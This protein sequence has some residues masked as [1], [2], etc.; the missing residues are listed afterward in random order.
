V[1]LL[2]P[3]LLGGEGEGIFGANFKIAGPVSDPKITV[4]P[5]SAL[6]P[7]ILR[8]LF[9]FDAPS[10]TPASPPEAATAPAPVR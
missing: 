6:A 2:G 7:G 4:N 1:P 5:L 9:L 8:K 3:I 10:A